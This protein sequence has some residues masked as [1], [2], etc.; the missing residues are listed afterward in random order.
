MTRF[1]L[2]MTLLLTAAPAVA[3]GFDQLRDRDAFVSAIKDR[4]LTRFGIR[5]DVTED[6]RIDGHAFGR[7]VTGAWRW[8]EGYFCRD[9]FWGSRNLG[10]NCQ[11]VKLQGNTIRFISDHGTGR[12]ADLYLR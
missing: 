12:H 4:P 5:L 6:G 11:A 2:A 8:T 9:L 1:F 10:A 7:S 3:E